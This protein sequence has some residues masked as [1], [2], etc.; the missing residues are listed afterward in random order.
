MFLL[1]YGESWC[2]TFFFVVKNKLNFCCWFAG[3]LWWSGFDSVSAAWAFLNLNIT[4][5]ML[6]GRIY[7]SQDYHV[8]KGPILRWLGPVKSCICLNSFNLNDWIFIIKMF[9]VAMMT[10]W[11]NQWQHAAMKM[12]I[13]RDFSISRC[14]PNWFFQSA[15][16]SNSC[17]HSYSH[18]LLHLRINCTINDLLKMKLSFIKNIRDSMWIDLP[19]MRWEVFVFDIIYL[20]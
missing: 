7:T 5:R 13:Q 12:C 15:V 10:D 4:S 20:S 17:L 8:M 9:A 14:Q 3:R 19:W 11:E 16:F 2:R 18:P 6:K 1:F